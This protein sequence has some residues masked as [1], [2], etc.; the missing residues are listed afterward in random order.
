MAIP[1]E[2][3]PRADRD[4]MRPRV[5]RVRRL[6]RETRDTF[7]LEIE[8]ANSAPEPAFAPGQFNMLYAF[9]KGEV[10]ISISGDPG[11]P[12]PLVHTVRVV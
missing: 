5:Y 12:W 1:A 3:D 8:P 6:R 11:R 4:P 10:P 7:T 2:T 9:G